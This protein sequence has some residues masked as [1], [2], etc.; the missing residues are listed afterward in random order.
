MRRRR[1]SYPNKSLNTRKRDSSVEEDDE[2]DLE[3]TNATFHLSQVKGGLAKLRREADAL[4]RQNEKLKSDLD[5]LYQSENESIQPRRGK[6]GGPSN[7]ALKAQV[8]KL[9]LEVEKLKTARKEDKRKIRRLEAREIRAEAQDLQE[10]GVD[11]E[12]D[13]THKFRKLLRE[14]EDLVTSNSYEEN[15]TCPICF[16]EFQIDKCRS[17]KCEHIFCDDCLQ[18]LA[19]EKISVVCPTCRTEC[20]KDDFQP[21]RF[22]AREQWDKLVAVVSAFASIDTRRGELD[23]TDEEVE[24]EAAANFIVDDDESESRDVEPGPPDSLEVDG[25]ERFSTPPAGEARVESGSYSK[26]P[27]AVKRK[28]LEELAQQRKRRL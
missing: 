3:V 14:V 25:S 2:V 21:I 10:E 26:S 28:R 13:V 9:E 8:Q 16:E 22:S 6:K 11:E 20:E 23:T 12:E 24:E 18:N 5:K 1:T 4:R 27:T 19:L 15:E 17:L 7:T